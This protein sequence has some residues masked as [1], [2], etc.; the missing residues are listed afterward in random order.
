MEVTKEKIKEYAQKYDKRY[1]STKDEFIE[2]EMK[3]WLENNRFLDK[4]KFI[5]IGMWK[6]PRPKKY[7]EANSEEKVQKITKFSFKEESELER[8]ESL[9][10]AR[11][12][13]RGVSYPVASVILHFAFPNKYPILDFRAIWSLGW[14]QPKYY[15]FNFYQ[16]YCNEVKKI[17]KRTG[18]DIRK[19]DK[20]LWEYSKEN[21]SKR[22]KPMS[23][24]NNL[25]HAQNHHF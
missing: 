23:E 25:P 4:E 18:E 15:T 17:S 7:Y 21:Q 1:I 22:N 10:G 19:I 5:K 24:K 9:L 16:K 12:G 6:S 3:K 14:E 8:V 20:A 13:L 11:G 2:R